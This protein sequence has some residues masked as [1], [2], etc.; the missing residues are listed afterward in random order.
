[1]KTKKFYSCQDGRGARALPAP[2]HQPVRPQQPQHRPD[3]RAACH[4]LHQ[5]V[6]QAPQNLG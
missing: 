4:H 2:E 6:Q 3:G 1:M 5:G